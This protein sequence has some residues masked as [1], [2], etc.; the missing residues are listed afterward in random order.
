MPI[1]N[2]K[3]SQKIGSD[4]YYIKKKIDVRSFVNKEPYWMS[5]DCD[6]KIQ[7]NVNNNNNSKKLRTLTVRSLH[8]FSSFFY[9]LLLLS[10]GF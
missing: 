3:I 6:L 7:L 8:S 5:I 4:T 10:A 1:Q 2:T 9:S